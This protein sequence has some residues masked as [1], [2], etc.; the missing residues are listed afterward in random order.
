MW[1]SQRGTPPPPHPLW[2]TRA[3][4]VGWK[5]KAPAWPRLLI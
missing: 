3:L 2:K 5:G 4:S 1:W